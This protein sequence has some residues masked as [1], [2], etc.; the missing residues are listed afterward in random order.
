MTIRVTRR[1]NAATVDPDQIYDLDLQCLYDL[2]NLTAHTRAPV[3]PVKSLICNAEVYSFLGFAIGSQAALMSRIEVSSVV[4]ALVSIQEL[5]HHLAIQ[6]MD[7]EFYNTRDPSGDQ[8]PTA[9]G[10]VFFL[11]SLAQC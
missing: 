8:E 9:T 1:Q 10:Y 7:F 5:T 11:M 4:D 2:F 6:E 3:L